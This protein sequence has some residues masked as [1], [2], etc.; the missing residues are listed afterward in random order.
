MCSHIS[1]ESNLSQEEADQLCR[2][3]KKHKRDDLEEVTGDRMDSMEEEPTEP[4]N[5]WQYAMFV[6]AVRGRTFKLP[7]YTGEG[8]EDALDDLSVTDIM[9]NQDVIEEG[10]LCPVVDIPWDTYKKSW[11]QWRRAL[12]IKVLG[13]AFSFKMLEPQIK[14]LW[15]LLNGCELL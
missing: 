8:E 9:Q 2:S 6:E 1:L 13:K 5:V 10:E 3:I 15:N 4:G 7:F 12:I 11:Q 14:K